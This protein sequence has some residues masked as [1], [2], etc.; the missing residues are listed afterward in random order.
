MPGK[1]QNVVNKV[2]SR[3]PTPPRER[4]TPQIQGAFNGVKHNSQDL[5]EPGRR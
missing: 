1:G 4:Q 2:A 3:T 5:V